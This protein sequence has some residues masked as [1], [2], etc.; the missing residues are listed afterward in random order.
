MKQSSR[1]LRILLCAVLMVLCF[2]AESS[3]GIRVSVFGAHIDFLPSI[4]A[5]SGLFLGCPAGMVCGMLAGMLYDISGV[6]VEG[7]YP[8]YYMIGGIACGLYGESQGWRRHP[9]RTAVIAAVGMPAA[10]SIVRYLFYFQFVTESSLTAVLHSLLIQAALTAL[11]TLP[12]YWLVVRISGARRS[13][14]E[15]MEHHE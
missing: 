14:R 13:R 6:G 7:L 4:I 10:L 12:V 2:V 1:A 5:A 9:L 11:I 15:Q 8:I 3:V